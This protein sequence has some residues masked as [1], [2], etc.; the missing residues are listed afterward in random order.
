M[1]VVTSMYDVKGELK[2]NNYLIYRRTYSTLDTTQNVAITKTLASYIVFYYNG[3]STALK[4]LSQL[5]SKTY[6]LG[7]IQSNMVRHC[8]YI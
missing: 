5:G 3:Q 2:C 8:S 1:Q 6:I 7:Q 4:F